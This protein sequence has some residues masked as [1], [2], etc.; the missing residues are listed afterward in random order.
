MTNFFYMSIMIIEIIYGVY[1]MQRAINIAQARVT[2]CSLINAVAYG[3]ERVVL[4]SRGKPKA[5]IVGM[6]D[7]KRLQEG[8]ITSPT[9]ELF[10]K[11]AALRHKVASRGK[12]MSTIEG[13]LDTLREG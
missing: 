9:P 13:D 5:A 6:A 10:K 12:K 2:F 4:L 11:A 1:K 3:N 7:L 8:L